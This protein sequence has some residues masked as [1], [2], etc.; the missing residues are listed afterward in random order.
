VKTP[1][2][3][4][5]STRRGISRTRWRRGALGTPFTSTRNIRVPCYDHIDCDLGTGLPR[6][7]EAE[8]HGG[9][10]NASAPFLA[11]VRGGTWGGAE[12][13]VDTIG[14]VAG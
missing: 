4:R 8:A 9:N 6:G 3:T 13:V 2:L 7:H 14:E 11:G 10:G 1:A 5:G 12:A